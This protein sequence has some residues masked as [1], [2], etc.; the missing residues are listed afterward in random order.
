MISSPRKSVVSEK[1][2]M[3]TAPTWQVQVRQ[4]FSA[5]KGSETR[6]NSFDGDRIL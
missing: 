3:E 1:Q 2:T 4:G 6:S 5:E